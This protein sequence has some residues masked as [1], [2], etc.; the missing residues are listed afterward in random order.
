MI[1]AAIIVEVGPGDIVLC[2]LFLFLPGWC[3]DSVEY[4]CTLI[5]MEV[6]LILL[7][8]ALVMPIDGIDNFCI[9]F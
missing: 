8:L 6:F 2:I 5:V 9:L 1:E 3:S 4:D 7:A